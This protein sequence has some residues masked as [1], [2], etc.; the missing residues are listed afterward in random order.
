MVIVLIPSEIFWSLSLTM[1]KNIQYLTFEFKDFQHLSLPT[2]KFYLLL[3]LTIS[4]FRN[5]ISFI[6]SSNMSYILIHIPFPWSLL[7]TS[8][9]VEVLLFLKIQ[10][11]QISH[12]FHKLFMW[13]MFQ[14]LWNNLRKQTN[15]ISLTKIEVYSVMCSI[16]NYTLYYVLYFD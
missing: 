12:S 16:Y 4:C 15:V 11:K 5:V 2:F 14:T 3:S 6:H 7:S 9:V 10:L 13:N 8:L 1:A